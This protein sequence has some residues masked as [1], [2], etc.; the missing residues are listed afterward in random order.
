MRHSIL[1]DRR[2]ADVIFVNTIGNVPVHED[3][4]GLAATDGR[5]RDAAICTANPEHFGP[6]ALCELFEGVRV[7]LDR[8]LGEDA[9]AG[10]DAVD[11]V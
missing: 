7:F 1:D 10:N 8:A 5:L 2:G 11:G 3:V 4:A 9:V 6:L